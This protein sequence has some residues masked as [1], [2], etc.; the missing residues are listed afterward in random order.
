VRRLIWLHEL[1]QQSLDDASRTIY[2]YEIVKKMAIRGYGANMSENEAFKQSTRDTVQAFGLDRYDLFARLR[3][4]LFCALP[5]LLVALAWFPE[6]RTLTGA[7]LSLLT[8]CGVTYLLGQ[9]A[10]T[11]GRA[12][13]TKSARS[14][15]RLLTA[16]MLSH[17][18]GSIAAPTKQRYHAFIRTGGVH[19]PTLDEEAADPE[20]TFISYVSA[21]DWLLER[22]R[23]TAKTS[24][25]LEENIAY[26]FRR[27]LLG[28]K[29]I[30]MA[31]LAVAMGANGYLA[32]AA[33]QAGLPLMPGVVVGATLMG[34]LAAWV[35]LVTGSFVNDASDAYARRLLAMCDRLSIDSPKA[36]SARKGGA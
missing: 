30:A 16:T 9:I 4:A 29:P 35:L 24:L 10:R 11:R 18:D 2:L 23:A 33:H 8:A 36:E 5:L 20:S 12:L 17:R 31:I 3:P 25:L 22:T 7:A 14:S 19:V 13:E 32:Y 1:I 28:L 34:L 6:T 27:N 21:V 26:G 15:G